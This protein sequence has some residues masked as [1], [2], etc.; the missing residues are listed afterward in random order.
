MSM[1]RKQ[2]I[3]ENF[4]HEPSDYNPEIEG[5]FIPE[6]MA[7]P[8]PKKDVFDRVLRQIFDRV[9]QNKKQGHN[10]VNGKSFPNTE[11]NK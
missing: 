11:R 5:I 9:A 1:S 6:H 2:I 4:S 7:S 10:L 8:L 3:D